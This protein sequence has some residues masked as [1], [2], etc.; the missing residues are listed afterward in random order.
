MRGEPLEVYGDI[1]PRYITTRTEFGLL[2]S[3][4]RSRGCFDVTVEK[5]LYFKR[6][7]AI[8]RPK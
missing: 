2:I 6:H 3:N 1:H 8:V 7:R 5:A 4:T